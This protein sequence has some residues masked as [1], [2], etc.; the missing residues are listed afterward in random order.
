MLQIVHKASVVS[1]LD[2]LKNEE[3]FGLDNHS[4]LNFDS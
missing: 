1:F 2:S 3:Y 4:L